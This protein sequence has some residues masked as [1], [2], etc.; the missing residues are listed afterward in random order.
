MKGT[1]TCTVILELWGG[2][3]SIGE[4]QHEDFRKEADT[5]ILVSYHLI[6]CFQCLFWISGVVSSATHPWL[7]QQLL[8]FRVYIL[9]YLCLANFEV[10]GFKIT[11]EKNNLITMFSCRLILCKWFILLF[12]TYFSTLFWQVGNWH[13]SSFLFFLFWKWIKQKLH[14]QVLQ[15]LLQHT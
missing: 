10:R 8:H 13:I 11:Q 4:K 14:F 7:H 2:S 9:V 15:R 5:G 3:C 1:S 6:C 12:L